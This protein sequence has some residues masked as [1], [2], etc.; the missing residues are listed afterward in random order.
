MFLD[1]EDAI[2]FEVLKKHFD[3]IS[4]NIGILGD[5]EYIEKKI[6]SIIKVTPHDLL[7][8]NDKELYYRF[9]FDDKEITYYGIQQLEDLE[10]LYFRKYI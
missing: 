8:R 5:K 7:I 1:K 2:K 4:T 6:A 10:H 3:P 9:L